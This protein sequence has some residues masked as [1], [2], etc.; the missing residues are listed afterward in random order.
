MLLLCKQDESLKKLIR[1]NAHQVNPI[2]KSPSG[3][4]P[5]SQSDVYENCPSIFQNF[6]MYNLTDVR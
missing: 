3:K 6:L 4:L 1:K 5:I 2:R